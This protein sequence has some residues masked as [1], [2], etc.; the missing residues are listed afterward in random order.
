M[1][2]FCFAFEAIK[3][4]QVEVTSYNGI[5]S[6]T[7]FAFTLHDTRTGEKQNGSKHFIIYYLVRLLDN[8]KNF[9]R[10]KIQVSLTQWSQTRGPREGLM[11]PCEHQENEDF[12]RNIDSIGLFLKM[13][14]Y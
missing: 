7:T 5:Q 14:Q 13:I 10:F 9:L 2:F 4:K 8:K 1:K 3:L 11:R 12:I 6:V